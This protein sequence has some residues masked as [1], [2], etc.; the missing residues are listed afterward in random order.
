MPARAGGALALIQIRPGFGL[1]HAA[2]SLLQTG[3]KLLGHLAHQLAPLLE[4]VRLSLGLGRPGQKRQG[5]PDPSGGIG[6][7]M[8]HQGRRSALIDVFPSAYG[9]S[10]RLAGPA[11]HLLHQRCCVFSVW[12]V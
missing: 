7:S 9:H 6:V 8:A 1:V 10:L 5:Q 12:P 2:Q 4:A 3:L 11:G